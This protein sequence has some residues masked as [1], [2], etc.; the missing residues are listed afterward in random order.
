MGEML[1]I[2]GALKR[3]ARRRRLVA[4]WGGFWKGLLFGALIW[5]LV[6]GIYKL[7]PIPPSALIIAGWAAGAAVVAG[8][9]IGLFMRRSMLETARWVD[10][11]QKLQERL[12]TAL[13]ISGTNGTSEWKD[14]VVRD[15][16]DHAKEINPSKLL[17]FSLPQFA[18]WAALIAVL[19]AGLGF[20]PEYRTKAHKQKQQDAAVIRDV[21]KNLADFAK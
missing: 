12:S 4:A 14:L 11:R 3:A 20:V 15:A 2:E 9:L 21:G 6:F 18:K 17:P 19:G 1:L 5:L 7:Y 10:N 16:A 8:A 13:E